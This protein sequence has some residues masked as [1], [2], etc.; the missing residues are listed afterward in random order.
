VGNSAGEPHQRGGA[1]W[2]Y[3]ESGL[4]RGGEVKKLRRTTVTRG[5]AGLGLNPKHHA[6]YT[7]RPGSQTRSSR[8]GREGHG[9][10]YAARLG[11]PAMGRHQEGMGQFLIYCFLVIFFFL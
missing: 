8:M 11:R 7:P 1:R 4:R 9:L 5:G 6:S 3:H 10:A 2:R